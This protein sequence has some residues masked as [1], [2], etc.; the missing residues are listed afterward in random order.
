MKLIPRMELKVP[1]CGRSCESMMWML[2]AQSCVV[3]NVLWTWG[4]FRYVKLYAK[5]HLGYES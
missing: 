1:M 4:L 5:Y 3:L 2:F